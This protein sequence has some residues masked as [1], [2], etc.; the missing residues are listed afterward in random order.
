MG[1]LF[2]FLIGHNHIK[3]VY[4]QTLC[5]EAES[6]SFRVYT[7]LKM[8]IS[9]IRFSR[10][11]S[12]SRVSLSVTATVALRQVVANVIPILRPVGG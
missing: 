11:K 6:L 8:E 7:K 9:V 3:Y 1:L 4:L 2:Q 12:R 5:T 10:A